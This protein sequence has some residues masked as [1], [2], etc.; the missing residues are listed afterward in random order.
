MP[1][2]ALGLVLMAGV[3]T[4][5]LAIIAVLEVV[6]GPRAALLMLGRSRSR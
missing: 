6:R 1:S 3:I 4:P 2:M 5:L